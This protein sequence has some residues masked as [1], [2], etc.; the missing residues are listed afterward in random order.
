MPRALIVGYGSIGARHARILES[1]GCEIGVVSAREDVSYPTWKTLG[2]ALAAFE[3]THILVAAETSR[4]V[5]LYRELLSHPASLLI[6]KPLFS[7][8]EDVPARDDVYVAYNLRFH[9]VLAEMKDRCGEEP[10]FSAEIT[11]GSYLPD[12]RP[13]TDYRQCYSADAER[14][15]GVLRDLSH[16]L[17]AALWLFGAWRRLTAHGGH[18]SDLE[19]T[20]DDTFVILG[21]AERCRSLMVRLNYLDRWPRRE[22]VANLA[23]R[24]LKGDVVAA[25]LR[26][27][28][29]EEAFN[30]A[31]RDVTY[32]AMHEDWLGPRHRL[33]TFAEGME[34]M[35]T[36]DRVLRA[37]R[38]E[39]WT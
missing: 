2:E 33:C 36:I 37:S 20:S 18:F 12:W 23:G 6:E 17:D 34:T 7:E 14:G 3:P 25:T 22:Y 38:S 27:N 32:R 16:E 4:H 10:A 15:G 29:D 35:R 24:T 30:V 26:E 19:I 13:G 8:L 5:A 31:D 9:P 11:V 28:G 39:S 1:L 21:A